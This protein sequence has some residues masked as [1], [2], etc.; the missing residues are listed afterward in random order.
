ML[1]IALREALRALLRHKLRSALALLGVTIGIAA[2][3][4]TVAVGE[5][6][7]RRAREQLQLLGDNLIWVEAGSR[8]VGGVRLGTHQTRTL[9][10]EDAEAIRQQVP[11]IKAV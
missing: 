7:A 1:R 9:T 2:V 11:L 6:A 3:I 10:L 8:T 4:C 5:A